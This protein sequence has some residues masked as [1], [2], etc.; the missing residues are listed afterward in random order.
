VSTCLSSNTGLSIGTAQGK[1]DVTAAA[2]GT[3]TVLGHSSSGNNFTITKNAAGTL[4]RTCTTTG[5]GGCP[6]SGS[7]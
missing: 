3:Y 1:V 6:S 4:V 2:A 7:W 5:S